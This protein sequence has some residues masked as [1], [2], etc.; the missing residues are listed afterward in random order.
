M[1][2]P[3]FAHFG[4]PFWVNGHRGLP[5]AVGPATPNPRNDPCAPPPS[6]FFIFKLFSSDIFYFFAFFTVKLA[7]IQQHNG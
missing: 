6:G 3:N 7:Y 5:M 1:K 4:P 2:L